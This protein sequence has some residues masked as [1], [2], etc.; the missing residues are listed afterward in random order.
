M[1]LVCGALRD[2]AGQPTP[3]QLP[4]VKQ[5]NTRGKNIMKNI[6]QAFP[7]PLRSVDKSVNKETPKGHLDSVQYYHCHL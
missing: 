2:S 3:Y 7:L 6:W 5:R 4:T 1:E